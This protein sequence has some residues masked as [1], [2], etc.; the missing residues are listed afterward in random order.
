MEIIPLPLSSLPD[1]LKQELEKYRQQFDERNPEYKPWLDELMAD[2][3]FSLQLQRCWAG[4]RYCFDQCSR[5]PDVFKALV[6]SQELTTQYQPCLLYTSPS[7]RD[8]ISSR[9]PSSA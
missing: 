7:P 5:L 9:M 6:T 2:Q 8:D 4:S 3:T 1:I